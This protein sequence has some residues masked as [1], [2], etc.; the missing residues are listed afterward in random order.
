L[1]ELQARRN[2]AIAINFAKRVLPILRKY[3]EREKKGFN[4][5]M[6]LILRN[7]MQGD[8]PEQRIDFS[9]VIL[10]EGFLPNPKSYKVVSPA[11]G[12]LEFNWSLERRAR[13]VSKSDRIFI[14]VYCGSKDEF[15]H[16]QSGAERRERQ[17][18]MD[19]SGFSG[20]QVEVYFGFASLNDVFIS[21]SIYAGSIKVM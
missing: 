6:S 17:F 7:A 18:L 5:A 2:W 13:L 1:R 20:Q 19:V 11:K 3:D 16:E 14:A 10:G 12:L 9:K 15:R 4:K 8:H 21:T